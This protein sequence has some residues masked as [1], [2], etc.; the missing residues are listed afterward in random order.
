M[1]SNDDIAAFV[2]YGYVHSS[3]RPG[4]RNNPVGGLFDGLERESWMLGAPCAGTDVEAFFPEVGGSAKA[5][6]RI[7][8]GCDIRERCLQYAV[9]RDERHGVWGGLSARERHRLRRGEIVEFKPPPVKQPREQVVCRYCGDPILSGHFLSRY[10]S[11]RCR[12]QR[13]RERQNEMRRARN[14]DA[15]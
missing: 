13:N 2:A 8:A 4:M 7:C 11:E 1:S 5:A 12:K 14:K 15:A 3:V 9:E 6:K 10:C